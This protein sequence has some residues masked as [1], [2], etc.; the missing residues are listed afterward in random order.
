V[1]AK[2]AAGAGIVQQDSHRLVVCFPLG[3][4]TYTVADPTPAIA[5]RFECGKSLCT[6]A[7]RLTA[8]ATVH[9][10]GLPFANPEDSEVDGW[11]NKNAPIVPGLTLLDLLRQTEFHFVVFGPTA[12]V[13]R[14]WNEQV[15]Y[16]PFSYPYGTDHRESLK[17]S[18]IPESLTLVRLANARARGRRLGPLR[19]AARGDQGRRAVPASVQVSPPVFSKHEGHGHSDSGFNPQ[20]HR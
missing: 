19:Q 7:V 14:R 13:K 6:V 1:D 18:L 11:V 2:Q 9:G 5:A 3:Q 16:P 10:F 4:L 17:H 15:L 12:A 8:R 20:P